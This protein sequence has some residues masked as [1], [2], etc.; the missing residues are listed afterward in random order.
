M[1]PPVG[2]PAPSLPQAEPSAL[3]T[4][5]FGV[6]VT[7]TP[8]EPGANR[9][10]V[11]PP[12]PAEEPPA[13]AKGRKPKTPKTPKAPKEPRKP[14]PAKLEAEAP[15]DPSA[16]PAAVGPADDR[17]RTRILVALVLGALLILAIVA[18][19]AFGTD[20]ASALGLAG[21]L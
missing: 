21:L 10:P 6:G 4:A 5:L 19:L 15:T 7:D 12:P 18:A 3:E 17:R 11:A 20:D 8:P 9:V 1:V 13:P 2:R 16:A 14:K